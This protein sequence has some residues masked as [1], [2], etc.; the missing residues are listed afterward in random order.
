M[1]IQFEIS[2]DLWGRASR[3]IPKET[4]RNVFGQLAFEEWV[5]RREGRDKKLQTE[6]IAASKELLRSVV[7]DLLA[8]LQD[9]PGR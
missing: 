5:T 7:R 8:E 1:R 3:Y 6:R 2:D 9:H 4:A